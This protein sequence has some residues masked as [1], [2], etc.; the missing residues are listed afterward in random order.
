LNG[1]GLSEKKQFSIQSQI[2]DQRWIFKS[3]TLR[4]DPE[5]T[6]IEFLSRSVTFTGKHVLEI[7]SGDGRLTWRFAHSARRVSGIDLDADSLQKA[8]TDRP[9]DLEKIASFF[10]ASS[11]NLP[12]SSKA[13]DI[14]VL[15][16]SL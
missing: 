3:M 1:K 9:I 8:V 10:Q 14:A 15:A 6:E 2:I 5:G 12:F 13:F 11:I 7:G 4:K 16:W